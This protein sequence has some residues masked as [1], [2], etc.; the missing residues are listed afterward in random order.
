MDAAEAEI[1]KIDRERDTLLN[2][3]LG[4]GAAERLHETMVGLERRQ[5]NLKAILQEAEESPSLLHPNT[6]RHHIQIDELYA[7]IQ[8]D[9][10]AK[11]MVGADGA[12][13][14][15]ARD[16]PK[17]KGLP[18]EGRGDRKSKWLRGRI[19]QDLRT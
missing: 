17:A 19:D 9:L 8:K 1:K 18:E 7:A 6:P 4:S 14:A 15:G 3:V 5:K 13:F 12:T 16:H 11:R 10:E 2:L